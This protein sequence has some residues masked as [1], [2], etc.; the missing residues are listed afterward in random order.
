[1]WSFVTLLLSSFQGSSVSYEH[2]CAYFFVDIYIQFFWI[3]TGSGIAGSY[4]TSSFNFLR[5]CQTI[6]QKGCT[7]LHFPQEW[8]RV[9]ISPH[10]QHL[11]PS[12]LF[13]AML[14]GIVSLS[15]VFLVTVLIIL[16]YTFWLIHIFS[17]DKCL[18][19]SLS[20]FLNWFYFSFHWLVTC[21]LHILD[22]IPYHR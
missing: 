4:H 14:V 5:D 17:L 22:A 15:C 19:R 13:L 21:P 11:L 9:S 1:M 7:I 10:P 3:Y 16:S 12:F 18:F 20:H 2:W 8:M 6:F